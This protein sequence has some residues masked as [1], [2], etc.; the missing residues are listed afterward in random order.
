MLFITAFKNYSE[1]Q[2]LFGVRE[3]D[4]KKARKN[5]ILLSLL[6]DKAFFKES[7]KSGNLYPFSIKNMVNLRNYL[8]HR[9]HVS[10]AKSKKL[11][12]KLW[13][14]DRYY[15]SD[16]YT[17][18]G[19]AG[20]CEDG[21]PNAVRYVNMESGR[22]F[23][24]KA[25]KFYKHLIESTVF[26]RKLNE[27]LVIWLCEEFCRDWT[28]HVIGR[29]PKNKL[30]VNDNFADIYDSDRLKGYDVKD[31]AFVSCMV[32]KGLDSFYRDA[33][34]AK[35]AYLEDET[36]KIIARCVIF[37]EV[38]DADGEVWRY[39]ER[40]YSVGCN[41]VYKQALVDALI[42]AGE[43]DCFKKVGA[44]CHDCHAI[45]DVH[46]NSLADKKFTIDCDLDW[47]D[48]LSY[49]D[50]FKSY[51]MYHRTAYNDEDASEYNL[52]VTEGSLSAADEDQDPEPD[53]YD[54]YHECNAYEVCTVY[55]HGDEE[56]CDVE[57]REDF[58]LFQGKWYH[59]DD[60]V[61]CPQ[62]GSKMLNPDY[63]GADDDVYYSEVTDKSY[64]DPDCRDEA[65]EAYKK[66]NWHY[67]DYDDEWYE[68][69]D[70]L[71]TYQK[72]N[73]L[74]CQY[75]EKTITK[76]SY[77]DL[78]DNN[79]LHFWGGLYFDVINEEVGK[80]YGY[81]TLLEFDLAA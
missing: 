19:M 79:E 54:S 24:M 29:L 57:D 46:G 67:S 74:T 17:L 23:K 38:Y 27:T 62:C 61:T 8:V 26:G 15:Y 50:T 33:V 16:K 76:D 25:G 20:V 7:V 14:L 64:C 49:Q 28:S 32:N 56:T 71:V 9:I 36:G 70:D 53:E 34:N 30:Y 69:K 48:T 75:E 66:E 68:D 12:H 3:F 13:L 37:T 59:E 18:D 72:F 65:E 45:V 5:K 81:E 40:Q 60:I 73:H 42:Q 55:Y 43:I 1:F 78:I 77:F 4:G 58:Q 52:A 44:S 41:D 21:T 31:D 39:A 10:G 35:A 6:K 63:Y 22:V 2:E 47:D 51:S 11:C 80:P